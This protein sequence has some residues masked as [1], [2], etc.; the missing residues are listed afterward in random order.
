MKH[1]LKEIVNGNFAKLDY[2]NQGRIYYRIDVE[3]T[4][5]QL[6]INSLEDE[7]KNEHMKSEYKSITLMRWIRNGWD[8]DDFIQLN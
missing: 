8:N 4:I 3:G 1:T 7:W 6:T 5:Y 2:I